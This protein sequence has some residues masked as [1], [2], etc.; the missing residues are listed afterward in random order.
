MAVFLISWSRYPCPVVE[1]SPWRSWAFHAVSLHWGGARFLG[2][3]R[4]SH[5]GPDWALL[6]VPNWGVLLFLARAEGHVIKSA[7]PEIIAFAS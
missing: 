7:N 4:G 6:E 2:I 1:G 5:V 3:R